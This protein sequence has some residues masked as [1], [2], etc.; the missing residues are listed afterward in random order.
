MPTKRTPIDRPQRRMISAE[1]VRLFCK[2]ERINCTCAPRDWEGEYWRHTPCAGCERWWELNSLLMRELRLS[3]WEF[4]S[5]TR[6]TAVCPY[7][8]DSNA[9]RTWKPDTRGHERYR[10]LE[11][12][13]REARRR[14][15]ARQP[16]P[17][18]PRGA[19]E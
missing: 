14:A 5:Y 17:A 15:R 4:P 12:A 19:A 3:S 8:A 7:P 9:A 11:G 18:T 6:P 2:M 16:R 13:A 1:A 10:Q